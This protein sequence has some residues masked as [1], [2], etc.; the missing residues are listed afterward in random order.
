[1]TATYGSSST[2]KSTAATVASR[3][4]RNMSW[5]SERPA[6]G[7]RTTRLPRATSTPLMGTLSVSGDTL[8]SAAGF[9]QGTPSSVPGTGGSFSS[10]RSSVQISGTSPV[11]CWSERMAP[12]SRS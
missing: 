12:W 3:P 11:T 6:P 2:S 10:P 1:M 5:A 9:H 4:M 7:R 8:A